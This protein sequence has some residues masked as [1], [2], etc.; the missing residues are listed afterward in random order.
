MNWVD[1]IRRRAAA[2]GAPLNEETTRTRA[3]VRVAWGW[4]RGVD[5]GGPGRIS[6]HGFTLK[7]ASP[8]VQPGHVLH[9]MWYRKVPRHHG[10][11]EAY[12]YLAYGCFN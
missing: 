1:P 11:C 6:G 10:E 7:A 3:R 5:R 8:S 9:G 4:D 2:I 12:G